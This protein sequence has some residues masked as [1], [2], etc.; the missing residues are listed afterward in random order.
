MTQKSLER[1]SMFPMKRAH[2]EAS[3]NI[4]NLLTVGEFL[5]IQLLAIPANM[6]S[7]AA[8]TEPF[9]GP[10]FITSPTELASIL[11]P[12]QAGCPFLY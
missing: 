6:A 12:R 7:V 5:G 1:F 11:F 8:A 3:V 4:S 9:I 10:N 2:F